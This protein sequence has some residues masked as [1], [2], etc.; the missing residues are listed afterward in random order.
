[1]SRLFRLV[2]FS[3]FWHRKENVMIWNIMDGK[4]SFEGPEWRNISDKAKDFISKLLVVIPQERLTV[5]GALSHS[6][7]ETITADEAV[8]YKPRISFKV[9]ALSI[10]VL[11]NLYD[12]NQERGKL[13]TGDMV[14]KNPYMFSKVRKIVDTC[15]FAIYGHWVKRSNNPNQNRAAIYENKPKADLCDEERCLI[16]KPYQYKL[17]Y[18]NKNLRKTQ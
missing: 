8:F 5:L 12:L 7:F 14:I 17:S 11:K 4:Y 16:T 6:W 18:K 10:M 15:A 1:M 9:L 13:L 2:G 3:P